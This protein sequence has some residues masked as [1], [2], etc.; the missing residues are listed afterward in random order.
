MVIVVDSSSI[1]AAAATVVVFFCF[2]FAVVNV[3]VHACAFNTQLW[4][5]RGW[6]KERNAGIGR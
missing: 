3:R 1:V 4:I 5:Q 6:K 2:L